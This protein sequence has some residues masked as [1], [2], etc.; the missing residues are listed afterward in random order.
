MNTSTTSLKLMAAFRDTTVASQWV[1]RRLLK[2]MSEPAT[3]LS[4]APAVDQQSLYSSD[5]CHKVS[6]SAPIFKTTWSVS[7]SLFDS[8]CSVYLS[9]PLAQPSLVQSLRFYTD[10]HIVDDPSTAQFALLNLSEWNYETIFSRGSL[11]AP[12]ESCTLI[13]QVDAIS[14]NEEAVGNGALVLSG[15]GIETEKKLLIH[16]L[17]EQHRSML[18]D[19]TRHYPC[20]MDFI[21]CDAEYI[22]ALPRSTKINN[23]STLSS[24]PKEVA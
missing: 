18:I 21:F 7:Q 17:T 9:P 2:A 24:H 22:V 23:V 8:D 5:E 12:H 20:G 6:I 10:A 11:T 4:L 14:V 16:G 19:N 13:I 1:Y 15:P 3:R